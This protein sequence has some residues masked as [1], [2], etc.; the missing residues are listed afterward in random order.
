MFIFFFYFWVGLS[1][2]YNWFSP[3]AIYYIL[4][5][6]IKFHLILYLKIFINSQTTTSK[7]IPKYSL[8]FSRYVYFSYAHMA[9]YFEGVMIWCRPFII[10]FQPS[11]IFKHITSIS[12]QFLL[13]SLFQPIQYRSL[14]S[15]SIIEYK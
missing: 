8:L 2:F 14:S 10:P 12:F 7:P 3:A 6:F 4:I 1:L 15:K 5:I 9:T 11:I 13:K